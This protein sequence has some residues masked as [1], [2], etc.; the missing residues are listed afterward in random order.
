VSFDPTPAGPREAVESDRL[1]QARAEGDPDVDTDES[2]AA[3]ETP[4]PR[5]TETPPGTNGTPTPVQNTPVQA[6]ESQF[7][8]TGPEPST[9]GEGPGGSLPDLPPREHLALGLV[10]VIGAAAGVRRS[11]LALRLVRTARVRFQRRR[12]PETDVD[13]AF[14][15]MAIVLERNHRPREPGETVRQYLDAIGAPEPALKLAAIHERATYGG[16]VDRTTADDAVALV[17]DIRTAYGSSWL[18]W[19]RAY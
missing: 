1:E 4:T 15:R 8:S 6:N 17:A 2:R 13:V 7:G 3:T 18:P 19:R 12:D 10:L 14:E 9:V 11:G 5:P 16:S